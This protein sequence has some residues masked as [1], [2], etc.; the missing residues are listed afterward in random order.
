MRGE[1]QIRASFRCPKCRNPGC[2][3][4]HATVPMNVLPLPVGRY[5]IAT[6]SLCGFTEWYDEAVVESLN[7]PAT[8]TAALA[9]DPME[10]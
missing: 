3:V 10:T 4:H 5:L 9:T 6:C 7:K 1:E 8:E 2:L